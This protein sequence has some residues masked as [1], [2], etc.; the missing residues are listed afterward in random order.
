MTKAQ[1]IKRAIEMVNNM[2]EANMAIIDEISKMIGEWNEAHEEE[3]IFMADYEDDDNE[4]IYL[5]FIEDERF[6]LAC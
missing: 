6:E 1:V 5:V 2:E 3:E 4:E